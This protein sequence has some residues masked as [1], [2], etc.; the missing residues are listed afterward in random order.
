MGRLCL[1]SLLSSPQ[2]CWSGAARLCCS[3]TCPL[4]AAPVLALGTP[5]S[6]PCT[7]ALSAEPPYSKWFC[8]ELSGAAGAQ[9]KVSWAQAALQII[10]PLPPSARESRAGCFHSPAPAV[11]AQPRG[12]EESP[13]REGILSIPA[14]AMGGAARGGDRDQPWCPLPTSLP[15]APEQLLLHF[16]KADLAP[17]SPSPW[18]RLPSHLR[19][20][21]K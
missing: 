17:L 8:S 18:A 5:C 14:P 21:H 6:C 2:G 11:T 15:V 10:L 16:P 1:N 20:E 13:P 3:G 9:G 4:P 7:N 19:A 12:A